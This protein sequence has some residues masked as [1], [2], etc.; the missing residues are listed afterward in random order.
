MW[1]RMPPLCRPFLLAML[2]ATGA[3]AAPVKI[4]GFD[5]MSCRAWT[6]SREDA[7]QRAAY[8]AWIRGLLTGHNY[9]NQQQQVS[10]VSSGTVENY[11]DRYCV[12][13]PGGDFGEAAMRMT[14]RFSGRN[15]AITK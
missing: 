11:I 8:L 9:A 2:I 10:A 5:D 1:N 15:S 3:E 6:E 7:G 4:V 12:E 14:D 13:K